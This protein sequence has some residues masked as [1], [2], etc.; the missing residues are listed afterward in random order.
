M[1]MYYGH[2][3][4]LIST[5]YIKLGLLYNWYAASNAMLVNSGWVLP[6]D[7]DWLILIQ[8][9]G[10]RTVAGGK[11]KELGFVNW[12]TPN[13]GATNEV[14]FSAVGTGY[15]TFTGTFNSLYN[16]GRLWSKTPGSS[17]DG[18]SEILTNTSASIGFTI[19]HMKYGEAVRIFRGAREVELLL[20]DG[21]NCGYYI[22]NDNKVYNTIKIGT[23]VWLASNL[24]ETKYTNGNNIP[25]V[26]DNSIWAG[27]TTGA[28]CAYNN[29]WNNV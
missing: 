4:S 27:L 9:L 29:D 22:G 16:E 25:E 23:Q 24:A 21:S 6:T 7:P 12:N 11:L 17:I 1:G 15:R 19:D 10:G 28:L 3:Q 2:N 13:T 20:S 8:Y 5:S 18:N 14:N 26:T